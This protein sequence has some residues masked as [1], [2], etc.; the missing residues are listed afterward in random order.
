MSKVFDPERVEKRKKRKKISTYIYIYIEKRK[1]SKF[2]E[3]GRL[4]LR[5]NQASL[6]NLIFIVLIPSVKIL[7]FVDSEITPQR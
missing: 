7:N 5:R 4:R 2:A 3:S 6:I 1:K